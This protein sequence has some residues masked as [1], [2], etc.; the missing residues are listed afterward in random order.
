ME[1]KVIVDI[2]SD[3]KKVSR[4]LV[5]NTTTNVQIK[6]SDRDTRSDGEANQKKITSFHFN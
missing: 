5:V 4:R 1:L 3:I 6:V 2:L